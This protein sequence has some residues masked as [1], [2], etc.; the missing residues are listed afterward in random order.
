M[1]K[2]IWKDIKGSE[3]YYLV[4]NNGN[5][6]TAAR[7]VAHYRGGLSKLPEKIKSQAI[8]PQGYMRVGFCKN[9]KMSS[10]SVHR[11]VAI[12]FISN[13]ENKQEVNHINGNKSDNRV[14]NLE[15][16]TP[17]EN[18]DHAYAQN[19]VPILSGESSYSSFLKENDVVNIR[20][21]DFKKISRKQLAQ[22]YKVSVP[23]IFD[24]IKRKTSKHI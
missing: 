9:G 11:L 23:T 13:K 6:K 17:K 20:N 1:Q 14:E 4:S 12:A 22:K 8:H 16:C 2:E 7:L 3:G 24:I 18:M 5:V 19:L 21:A 10:H 15:W